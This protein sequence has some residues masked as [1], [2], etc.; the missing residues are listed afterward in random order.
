M[1]TPTLSHEELYAIENFR[2]LVEGYGG[3]ALT[4]I[5]KLQNTIK[6]QEATIKKLEKQLKL[7]GLDPNE[8]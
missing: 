7:F 2:E 6:E 5:T 8:S 4:A 3:I 1:V